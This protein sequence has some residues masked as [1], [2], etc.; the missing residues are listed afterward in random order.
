MNGNIYIYTRM[1]TAGACFIAVAGMLLRCGVY[2]IMY[3]SFSQ[4]RAVLWQVYLVTCAIYYACTGMAY[5]LSQVNNAGMHAAL[6]A[7]YSTLL[8]RTVSA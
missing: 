3:Y 4:P 7:S 2:L 5:F 1:T 8:F 6:L